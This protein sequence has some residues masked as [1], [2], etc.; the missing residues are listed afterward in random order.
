MTNRMSYSPGRHCTRLCHHVFFSLMAS[1]SCCTCRHGH[2]HE[3]SVHRHQHRRVHN[4]RKV[5]WWDKKKHSMHGSLPKLPGNRASPSEAGGGVFRCITVLLQTGQEGQSTT[6]P[7]TCNA[8]TLG[9]GRLRYFPAVQLFYAI[10][11]YFCL[12]PCYCYCCCCSNE[13]PS[14]LVLGHMTLSPQGHL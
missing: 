12:L 7:T 13:G 8:T 5:S 3:H 14:P 9:G 1:N 4:V 2:R 6:Q 10:A 11:R